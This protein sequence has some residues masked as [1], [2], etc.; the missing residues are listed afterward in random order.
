MAIRQAHSCKRLVENVEGLDQPRHRVHGNAGRKNGHE[1]ERAG[2]PRAGLLI[3]AEAEKF[4][5]RARLGSVVER[6]HEDADKDHGWDS[7]NPVEVAGDDAVFGP[8]SAHP[9]DFL[10]AEVRGDESQSADPRRQGAPGLEVVFAGFHETFECE[11]DAQHKNEVQQ[12]DEP[13]DGGEVH[14]DVPFLRAKNVAVAGHC[15][16][17]HSASP[18]GA[19]PPSR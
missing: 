14:L 3:E 12:H 19:R 7:A 5:D 18:D 9:D 11:A 13:V 17:L 2:V 1:R 10:G 15:T 8:G 6:H 4:R 16:R